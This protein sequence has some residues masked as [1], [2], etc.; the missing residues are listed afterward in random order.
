M[1]FFT[2]VFKNE[3][4]YFIVAAADYIFETKEEAFDPQVP[5][6]LDAM[7]LVKLNTDIV[8]VLEVPETKVLNMASLAYDDLLVRMIGG[9]TFDQICE[10]EGYEI[11]EEARFTPDKLILKE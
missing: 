3:K 10:E 5:L 4:D 8:G 1:T 2:P 9:E 6:S 11:P 7:A